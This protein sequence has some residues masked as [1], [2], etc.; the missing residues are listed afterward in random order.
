MGRK[1]L[2]KKGY[3]HDAG[4]FA[5]LINGLLCEGRQ[6]LTAE[7]LTELDSQTGQFDAMDMER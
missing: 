3:F 1:D 7:D 4:R 2:Q 6:V 5:D